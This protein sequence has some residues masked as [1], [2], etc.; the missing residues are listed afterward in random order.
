MAKV[1]NNKLVRVELR[2]SGDL[3]KSRKLEWSADDMEKQLGGVI[4]NQK[5]DAFRVAMK[6]KTKTMTNFCLV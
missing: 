1:K 3:H 2:A 4:W 6:E 5:L